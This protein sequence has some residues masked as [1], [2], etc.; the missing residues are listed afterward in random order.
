MAN[1]ELTAAGTWAARGLV[2]L[3]GAF[4]TVFM[5]WMCARAWSA[6][7]TGMGIGSERG[8][9]VATA[10]E[11]ESGGKGGPLTAC[12]GTF[13]SN[14]G[15]TVVS[16]RLAAAGADSMAPGDSFDTRCGTTGGTCER[17]GALDVAALVAG[18]LVPTVVTPILPVAT[19]SLARHVHSGPAR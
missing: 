13:T 6:V 15:R 10:C 17:A 1:G 2:V 8:R 9:F 4:V 3:G 16:G 7:G 11:V 12:T 19:W 14:D 5:V 18:A